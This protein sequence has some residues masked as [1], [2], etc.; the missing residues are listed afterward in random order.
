MSA[1]AYPGRREVIGSRL[2]TAGKEEFAGAEQ[3]S[4]Y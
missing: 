4:Q 2:D 3:T 1:G